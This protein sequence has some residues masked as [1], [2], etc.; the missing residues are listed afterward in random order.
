MRTNFFSVTHASKIAEGMVLS[1]V[2]GVNQLHLMV[3]GGQPPR[4][5]RQ[6]LVHGQRKMVL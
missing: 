5:W 3:E 6:L 2:I 4:L 1:S